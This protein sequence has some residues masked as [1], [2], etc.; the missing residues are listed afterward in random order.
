MR[1]HVLGEG[2]GRSK[3]AEAAEIHE[4]RFQL[5]VYLLRFV[6]VDWCAGLRPYICSPL[7]C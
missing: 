4:E 2:A 5:H 7:G 3:R 6:L 1:L